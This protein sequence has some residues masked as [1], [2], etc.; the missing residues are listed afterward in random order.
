MK[1]EYTGL[2]AEKVDFGSYDIAT[3]SSLPSGCIQIVADVV[4][5]GANVCKNPTDTTQY[6]YLFND[7]FGP[8]IVEGWC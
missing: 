2:M 6:M 7:P 8:T 1:K 3:G 5:P 4:D